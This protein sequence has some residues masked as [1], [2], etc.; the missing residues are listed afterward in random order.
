[1][2]SPKHSC[3]HLNLCSPPRRP[4]CGQN[5]SQITDFGFLGEASSSVLGASGGPLKASR[6]SWGRPGAFWGTSWGPWGLSLGHLG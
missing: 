5:L 2:G 3:N 1:M 6:G 4:T